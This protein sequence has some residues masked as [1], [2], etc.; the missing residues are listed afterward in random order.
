MHGGICHVTSDGH[1]CDCPLGWTGAN[2]ETEMQV[3]TQAMFSGN[4]YVEFSN[5]FWV[6]RRQQ[7]QETLTLTLSTTEPN[8]LILWQGDKE[9]GK[10]YLAMS[11]SDGYVEFRYDGI[12]FNLEHS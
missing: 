1:S 7:T 5:D 8:G 6:H 9:R 3:S 10:D 11:L 2:C 4:S 12:S